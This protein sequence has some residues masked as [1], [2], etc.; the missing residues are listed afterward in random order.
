MIL[1]NGFIIRNNTLVKNDILIEEGLIK[2]VSDHIDVKNQ[3][4]IDVDSLLI[5]PGA[6]DVHVHYREPGFINK[7]T[8]KTGTLSAAKGGITTTLAMPNLQPCPDS[9]EHLKV[10]EEIIKKDAIIE[11][12]PYVSLSK[13]EKGQELSDLEDLCPRVV[14]V[15]DDGVGVNNVELLKEAMQICKRHHKII[16]SHAEDTIDSKL[17]QGEYVAVRR[18]IELAKETKVKYHFCHLSTKESFDAVRKAHQEGYQNITCEV[19]PHHLFLNETMIKN[20]N[21]KMNPPLRSK[22][23]QEETIKA[24]LDGTASLIA[25]DHAPHKKEEKSQAYDKCPN[26]IIGLETM[27]PLVYTNLI[28]TKRATLD[29]FLAWLV[30]NPIKVFSLKERR[31]EPGFV[32]DLACLDITTEREYQEKEILSKSTNSPYIGMKLTGFNKMT[33]KNGKIIWRE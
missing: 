2:E 11:V 14:A 33:I 16:A 29:D 15:S 19:S 9:L 4:V 3:E 12:L 13:G 8:I 27:I 26:G 6:V 23:N 31:I 21:F 1:K 22:E 32:A 18:E 28:K 7:E 30:Y 24:L 25:S 20:G 5:I 10:E 17:P